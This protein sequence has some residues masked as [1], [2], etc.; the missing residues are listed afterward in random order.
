MANL[1]IE[2]VTLFAVLVRRMFIIVA[3]VA[4]IMGTLWLIGMLFPYVADKLGFPYETLYD[5][6]LGIAESIRG[7][8]AS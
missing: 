6:G 7:L 8:F 3:Q 4:I 5:L 2:L 1:L